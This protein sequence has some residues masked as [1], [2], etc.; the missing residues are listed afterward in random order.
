MGRERESP[1]RGSFLTRIRRSRLLVGPRR[2]RTFYL[3]L[4][5][6]AVALGARVA[7]ATVY[8]AVYDRYEAE[9]RWLEGDHPPVHAMV[10]GDAAKYY[11]EAASI[12]EQVR[13]GESFFVAGDGFFGPFL[14]PR[15]IAAYGLATGTMRLDQNGSVPTGQVYGFLVAQSALY[16]VAVSALFVALARV[17][18]TRMAVVVALFLSLEPTLV[19]FSARLMTETV[20]VSLLMLAVA[21]AILLFQAPAGE[22]PLRRWKLYALLGLLLGLM[23]LQRPGSLGLAPVFALAIFVHL[24]R[25]RLAAFATATALVA[26]P[27]VVVLLLLGVHNQAR[28]GFFGFVSPQGS[29]MLYEYLGSQVVAE[30]AGTTRGDARVQLRDDAIRMAAEAGIVSADAATKR[31]LTER[32]TLGLYGLYRGEALGLLARHPLTT[33]RVV[34]YDA[35][36]SLHLNPIDT[37]R[38]YSSIYKPEDP[39][40][41]AAQAATYDRDWPLKIAYSALVL[42]LAAAGWLLGRR[43]LPAPLNVL[44]VLGIVYF[45]LVSG[46]TGSASYRYVIPNLLFY[47]VYWSL[48]VGLVARFVATRALPALR[49]RAPQ[50]APTSTAGP[51]GEAS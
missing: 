45:P 7:V 38:R 28:A 31:E 19:Q 17:L 8:V 39:D 22:S 1:A 20:F 43:A 46:M 11:T 41:A 6:F 2:R 49:S 24:G 23:Y 21:A 18:D 13:D 16:A 12:I 47:A 3:A 33:A 5:L 50:S 34:A 30:G 29:F 51:P 37:Y 27:I 36:V 26:A 40:L 48:A 15:L 4:A 35:L 9:S 14:Y 44:L 32:E 42:P 25:S 10:K